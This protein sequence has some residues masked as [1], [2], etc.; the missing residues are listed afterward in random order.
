M[1]VEIL[2]CQSCGRSTRHPSVKATDLPGTIVRGT[3]ELCITCYKATRPDVPA[4]RIEGPRIRDVAREI[5]FAV[6]EAPHEP[7]QSECRIGCCKNPFMCAQGYR[8]ACH[9]RSRL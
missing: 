6:V 5:V 8:C 1:S 9:W 4:A 7:Q 2:K 3:R